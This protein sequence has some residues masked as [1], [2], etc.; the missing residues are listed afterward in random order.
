MCCFVWGPQG[1]ILPCRA[2][3]KN[4]AGVDA[5]VE[6]RGADRGDYGRDR[7]QAQTPPAVSS[8]ATATY[9]IRVLVWGLRCANGRSQRVRTA[10]S[11]RR[12]NGGR[13]AGGS[14]EGVVSGVV[15]CGGACFGV[16]MAQGF[17]VSSADAAGSP[18]VV[19]SGGQV[20]P[21][22]SGAGS[23]AEACSPDGSAGDVSGVVCSETSVC[24]S[25]CSVSM[26][27]VAVFSGMESRSG[28]LPGGTGFVRF[29]GPGRAPAM[30]CIGL[31]GRPLHCRR[32]GPF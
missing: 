30:Q 24:V 1:G 9:P 31:V 8:V 28:S 13:R 23:S 11:S 32:C 14:D 27:V 22:G 21:P 18:W 2:F 12:A 29:V 17:A 6:V 16:G 4:P 3:G 20:S 25:G 10:A 7:T 26:V 5:W 19:S 15:G